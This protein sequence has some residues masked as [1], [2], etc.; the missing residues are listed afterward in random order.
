M[1]PSLSRMK[2]MIEIARVAAIAEVLVH[3]FGATEFRATEFRATE[4]RAD[5]KIERVQQT[6]YLI[7]VV[8]VLQGTFNVQLRFR[9]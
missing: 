6:C 1:P 9:H 4:F 7:P 3:E 8:Q 2:L 5:D